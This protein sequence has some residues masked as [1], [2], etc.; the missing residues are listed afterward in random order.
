MHA[1]EFEDGSISDFIARVRRELAGRGLADFVT[2][3]QDGG[4][5]VVHFHWMGSSELRY[6]VA[7]RPQGFGAEL[8]G[9]KLSRFH[10]PFRQRFEDR[11]EKVIDTV[12]ARI[13]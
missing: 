13:I 3:R 2:V 10:A 5:L 6:R 9:Q 12:G 8:V 1:F 4:E 11:F 7:E